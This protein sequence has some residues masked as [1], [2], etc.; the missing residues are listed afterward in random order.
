MAAVPD[1]AR[2]PVA[3]YAAAVARTSTCRRSTTR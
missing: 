1:A 3:G 2:D